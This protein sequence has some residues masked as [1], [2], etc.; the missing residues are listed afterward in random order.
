MQ[1]FNSAK[2]IK[3]DSN[4]VTAPQARQFTCKII[5]SHPSDPK[6]TIVKQIASLAGMHVEGRLLQAHSNFC[7]RTCASTVLVV[8]EKLRQ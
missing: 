6:Q 8:N 3:K 4:T 5:M 1:A 2:Y 7:N